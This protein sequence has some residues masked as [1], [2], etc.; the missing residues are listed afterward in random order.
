MKRMWSPWR[1]AYI[2]SFKKPAK[3]SGKGESIFTAALKAKDDDKNFILWRGKYCFMI[4]NLYPYNSGHLMIV[5]YKQTSDIH[6]L[7]E[8]VLREVMKASLLGMKALE[9]VMKPQGFNF[10]ANIGRASGAGVDD[11]VHFH[12]VPRWNGD[13]N[14]MPVLGE[15]KIISE[16][17]RRTMLKLRKALN[18]SR[19]G[20]KSRR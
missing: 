5:P 4:M 20:S 7:S 12:I 3:A 10:G 17:M 16:D 1:S 8:S 2:E 18:T 19:R 15:T 14:F 11:H 6:K 9:K 13:T